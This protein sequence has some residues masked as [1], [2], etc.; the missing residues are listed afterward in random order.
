[1]ASRTRRILL[2]GFLLFVGASAAHAQ[3]RPQ[4]TPAPKKPSE[5]KTQIVVETSP[6][7]Q[8]Y[9]DEVFKGQLSPEGRLVIDNPK[10]GD[11]RLRV[12]LQGKRDFTQQ[13]TVVAGQTA[14]IR[15]QLA[16]LP[17]KIVV[18]TTPGAQVFLDDS[19]RGQADARGELA[20][21]NV[22]AGLH[23][24]RVTA[25]GKKESRQ[26]VAVKAGQEAKVEAQLA[27]VALAGRVK[28]NAKDGLHYIWI[29]PR[30]FQMGCSP[31]DGG[32]NR[33]EK[34]AHSVTFSKGFW[35][36]Q[37][38]VTVGAY[39]RFASQTGRKMPPAPSFDSA[40]GNGALPIVMV[41]WDEAQAYCQWAGGRLPTE[42]EWEYAARGGSA[43]ARYGPL[44]A[45]AWYANNSGNQIHAVGQKQANQFGLFD[46]LGNVWE[47]VNDWYDE[48]YYSSSPRTDPPGPASG[49]YRVL[50]GGSWFN[51]PG[52]VRVSCRDWFTPSG[53]VVNYGYRCVREVDRP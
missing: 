8:V 17:G 42:A 20:M 48:N 6:Q 5:K 32:C 50:R 47:W 51:F 53:R 2:A 4:V 7:A 28:E 16:D 40:W 12:S 21:A 19:S 38:E 15:A 30:T 13:V 27:D 18:H 31:G 23:T 1:M 45:V 52:V 33:D 26:N 29:P 37:T 24:L 35:I 10:R 49:Q 43:A 25:G 44:D 36:G 3:L 41:T 39:K 22:S 11:H 46:T 14:N 9:L 34:P